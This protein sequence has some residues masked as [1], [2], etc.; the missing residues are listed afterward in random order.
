M[1]RSKALVPIA[2]IALICLTLAG[3]GSGFTRHGRRVQREDG[4]RSTT[5]PDR[6]LEAEQLGFK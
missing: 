3:C 6:T 4:T 1:K 2:V 5:R